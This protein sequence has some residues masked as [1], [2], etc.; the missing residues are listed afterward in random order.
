MNPHDSMLVAV[1]VLTVL[2][3]FAAFLVY[4]NNQ[5]QRLEKRFG[6]EYGRAVSVHGNRDKAEAELIAREKRVSRFNIVPLAREN[7]E[8]Y[9]REWKTLQARFVDDPKGAVV[10]ADRLVREVMQRR[11]YPMGDFDSVAA[12]ISVDHPI[13]VE[14]YRAA[15]EIVL[16]D[17]R[18]QAD[19]EDLRKALVHYRTLFAELL[20]ADGDTET[21]PAT[22]TEEARR[23]EYRNP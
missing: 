11:G 21:V 20:Q 3:A 2:V 16:R 13:V 18:N 22:A 14:S 4:R 7:A 6:P 19:T 17:R 10:E 15:C 9:A 5:S 1:A 12:D 8:R 23:H